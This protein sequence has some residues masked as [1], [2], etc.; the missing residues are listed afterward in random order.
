MGLLTKLTENRVDFGSYTAD[1]CFVPA[2]ESERKLV[3]ILTSL[4]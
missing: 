1:P 3:R 4:T 2:Q